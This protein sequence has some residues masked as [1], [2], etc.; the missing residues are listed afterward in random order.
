MT[1]SLEDEIRRARAQANILAEE[2]RVIEENSNERVKAANERARK[3]KER[4]QKLLQ[5][6]P[7]TK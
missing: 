6:E 1:G 7:S 2:T 4:L 5:E 3:A